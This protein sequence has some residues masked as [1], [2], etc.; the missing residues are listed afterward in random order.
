MLYG[1]EW[2]V[3]IHLLFLESSKLNVEETIV[4]VQINGQNRSI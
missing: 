3:R 2:Q 4:S 1:L